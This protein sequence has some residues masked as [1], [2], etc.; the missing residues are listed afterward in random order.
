MQRAS[1]HVRG[2]SSV[3]APLLAVMWGAP[4]PGRD[5]RRPGIPAGQEQPREWRG[6]ALELEARS[7]QPG[8]GSRTH[9][10]LPAAPRA[11]AAGARWQRRRLVSPQ[12]PAGPAEARGKEGWG[13][14][15]RGIPAETTPWLPEDRGRLWS[16]SGHG[17]HEHAQVE[18]TPRRGG[19]R[20]RVTGRLA[21]RRAFQLTSCMSVQGDSTTSRAD[22]P[23]ALHASADAP[24]AVSSWHRAPSSRPAATRRCASPQPAG[25]ASA[26]QPAAS[27]CCRAASEE[28]RTAWQA[29]LTR[30]RCA[31]AAT[32]SR[33]GAR[34][35]PWRPACQ[36]RSPTLPAPAVHG[37][38]PSR[39][40]CSSCASNASLP[41]CRAASS[42]RWAPS[43]SPGQFGSSPARSEAGRARVGFR[44]WTH[45][46]LCM[47]ELAN[48]ACNPAPPVHNTLP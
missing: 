5:K 16:G 39:P 29:G 31:R 17:Q 30:N 36:P 25:S 20:R 32:S 18:G 47:R 11:A 48:N 24:A 28:R 21:H 22:S 45:L 15:E 14:R 9:P 12:R 1:G 6:C 8:S 38:E 37:T 27:S 42:R 43:P 26:G 13:P 10:P 23:R 35:T 7:A 4:G 41:G 46:G 44:R 2:G 33:Q 40:C 19:A 34:R 3:A